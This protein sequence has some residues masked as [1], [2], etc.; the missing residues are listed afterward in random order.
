MNYICDCNDSL[1]SH[2]WLATH[3]SFKKGQDFLKTLMIKINS[4][5]SGTLGGL[6][7]AKMVTSIC[8]YAYALNPDLALDFWSL[9]QVGP[10]ETPLDTIANQILIP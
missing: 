1:K 7:G 3:S 6:V 5:L 9:S 2:E 10:G 8:P 4:S